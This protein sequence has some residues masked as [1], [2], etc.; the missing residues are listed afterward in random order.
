MKTELWLFTMRFPYGNGESFLETE[1]PFLAAGFK[2]VRI[3]PLMAGGALRPLPPNAEVSPVLPG[4][5]VYQPLPMH[6]LIL[7]LPRFLKIWVACRRSAPSG[8][9]F[10]AKRRELFS[11][12]R[13]AFNRER[14]LKATVGKFYDPERVR[15]YSYWTSDWATVLGAWKLADRRV[16]FVSRMHGF[17]LYAER[18]EDA[19]PMLQSF[20][21]QQA[22]QVFVA[23]Q[24]G[25]DDL[26]KRYPDKDDV[27]RLA[28]L[29]TQ[30]NGLGPWR[31]A[32]ELRVVSCANFVE[33][34]RVP[35]IAESLRHVDG[36]VRWTHF[37]DG[38]ERAQV[39]DVVMTLPANVQ[40]ELMGSCPN[41]EVIAWYK[42]NPVDVFVHASYTEGGAPVALQ[43]AASFGIPLV[44][45]DAGGVCEIV[46]EQ[47]GILLPNALTPE[48]LGSTLK[49]FRQ[50]GWY[51]SDA[52]ARVRAFW[53]GKFNAREVYGR[54]LQELL[55][56]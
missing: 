5:Q 30:D 12:L 34:K 22:K 37:G 25:L 23:S 39:E 54:M 40:V 24:A 44:A 28:R 6:L 42:A 32:E 18:S 56:N 2:R 27:F 8:R 1:L 45:A 10:T 16:E 21:V 31:P 43:E 35:L 4:K 55:K 14:L 3:F 47:S 41:A 51:A 49:G 53:S 26:L 48:L 7:A 13:Q 11:Q 20:H 17:D 19:W 15:L 29:G 33:L 36:P 46:T 9:V 50:S 38:P 52:R